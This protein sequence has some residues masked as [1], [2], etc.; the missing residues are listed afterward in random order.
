MASLRS[1]HSYRLHLDWSYHHIPATASKTPE[2]TAQE[3]FQ[4]G[5]DNSAF[6]VE[7]GETVWVWYVYLLVRAHTHNSILA[8]SFGARISQNP[9]FSSYLLANVEGDME[10][11]LLLVGI[12]DVVVD[13]GVRF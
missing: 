10:L 2:I 1:H 12:Q 4:I 13:R 7:A 5:D 6:R 8:S 9:S 11:L 3:W